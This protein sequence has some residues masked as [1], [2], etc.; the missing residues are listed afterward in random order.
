MQLYVKLYN[1]NFLNEG[2]SSMGMIGY[3]FKADEM[4]CLLGEVIIFSNTVRKRVMECFA[5]T[6]IV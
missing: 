5:S 1:I 6:G 4:V 2:I 3:Y